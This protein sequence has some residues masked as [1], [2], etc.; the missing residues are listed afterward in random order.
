MLE[1]KPPHSG[2]LVSGDIRFPPPCPQPRWMWGGWAQRSW[3][4]TNY[5]LKCQKWFNTRDDWPPPPDQPCA[6]CAL[7]GLLNARSD[8]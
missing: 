3:A 6:E 8:T 1:V 5:C 4:W 7:R 2:S